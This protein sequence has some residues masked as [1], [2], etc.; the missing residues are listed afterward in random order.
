MIQV[1]PPVLRPDLSRPDLSRELGRIGESLRDPGSAQ[2]AAGPSAGERERERE[3]PVPRERT[4][5][6]EAHAPP[7]PSKQ[8]EPPKE[9]EKSSNRCHLHRKPQMGCKICQR[10]YS[11]SDPNMAKKDERKEK[12]LADKLRRASESDDLYSTRRRSHEVFEIQN[13]QTFNFNAM[14]RDQILKNTYFKSL[15]NIETFEGIVDDLYK[16]ADTAEVYG[17]GTTTVPSTLFCCLFRLFTLGLSYDE[18]Q[19]LLENRG[20][21]F[22]RCCGF[23]YIRFG[24][25]T[26]KLWEHLGE[27]CLDDQEFEPS[28]S[29]PGFLVSIGEYVEAL[30]MDERYYFTALP[31]IPVGA[32]KKIEERIAPL[33]QYRKRTQSNKQTLQLFKEPGTPVEACSNGE[34][35]PGEVMH[36]DEKLPTRITVKVHLENG[37]DEVHHLGKIILREGRSGTSRGRSRSR[38]P[39][40]GHSPDL[41]RHAG[42]SL[43]EM[44]QDLRNRQKERAVC[45]SGK[46]YAR[47]PIGFMSGLALKRD[48]GVASTRLREEETYAPRQ[49]EHRK[50]MTEED[51]QELR[52]EERLRLEGDRDY[53]SK[54][55]MLY[56]KYGSANKAAAKQQESM[57]TA[58]EDAQEVLRLG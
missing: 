57:G 26:D 11:V 37:L 20:S 2:G 45:S 24:C 56:E 46:D 17:A 42:K 31:R 29:S 43:D 34:W 10:V 8:E 51:E 49:I 25:S 54:M 5:R 41:T 39:R 30:L 38:S 36:V 21:P 35:L 14:L 13:K 48:M 53:Q 40:R 19:L 18:L 9:D 50:Q 32:K 22:V 47:K 15:M 7:E 12:T 1:P 52:K 27:Y 3:R 28:K 33:G 58:S 23:L 55:Q 4:P 16:Y 44:V 6:G